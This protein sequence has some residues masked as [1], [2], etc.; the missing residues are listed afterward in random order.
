MRI[1]NKKE[2]LELQRKYKTDRKIGEVYGV[3]A[4]LVAY[5]RSKKKIG[6]YSQ[7]KYTNEQI[8]EYWER[9][10]DDG[11]AGAEL[12]ISA[13]GFR[14]WRRKYKIITTRAESG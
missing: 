2:L 1:P 9:F 7:P 5:W 13:A 8:L 3:P 4:R 10:G 11:R 14:Q 12:G 6:S